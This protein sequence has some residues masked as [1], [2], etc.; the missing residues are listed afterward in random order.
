MNNIYSKEII[1]YCKVYSSEEAP[2]YQKIVELTNNKEEYP[3]MISGKSI[4]DI[5]QL[6]LKLSNAKNVL[7]LGTFTGYSALKMAQV[8]SE[9]GIV[10]TIDIAPS[11]IAEFAFNQV[12][13]GSRIKQ[14]KGIAL[15]I[16]KRIEGKFDGL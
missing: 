9:D 11:P 3:Q 10:T 15:D 8:L 12:K 14:I 5:L 7:E 4:G 2:I 6:L 1:N 16:I 13:W